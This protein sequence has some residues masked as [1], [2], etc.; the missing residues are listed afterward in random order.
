MRINIRVSEEE[1]KMTTAA[2]LKGATF[3][4]EAAQ[5]IDAPAKGIYALLADYRVGHPSIVP[6]QYFTSLVVEQGGVGAG[7]IV[8]S[9]LKIWGK[10]F[11]TRQLVSEP[12]PGRVLAETDMETGQYTEFVFEPVEGGQKTNLVIASEFPAKPGFMGW[13]EKQV[14]MSV[15][16]RMYRQE[17]QNIAE[18]FQQANGR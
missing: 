1:N 12:Q 6:K 2:A 13:L 5:V 16:R 18:H 9:N 10:E 8:V 14:Q 11:S 17:L 7:T 15:I 3:H 4:V